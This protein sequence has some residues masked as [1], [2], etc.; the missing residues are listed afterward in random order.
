MTETLRSQPPENDEIDLLQLFATLYEGRH[1]IIAVTLA[2]IVLGFLY[3]LM[4]KP[5]YQADAL[6]QLEEKSGGGLA[7][8]ADIAE[9]FGEAPEVPAEIEILKSRTVLTRTIE[10]LAL[11]ITA[12]P[13]RLPVLGDFLRRWELPDPGFRFLRPYAWHEE[14]IAVSRLIVPRRLQDR[15][16]ILTALGEERYALD[17]GE[18]RV[19]KG[20]VGTLLSDAESGIELLVGRLIGAEGR[21]FILNAAPVVSSLASLRERFSVSE[22]GRKSSILQLVL[23]GPDADEAVRILDE[24]S[25]VYLLQNIA[26]S[27]AEAEASLTFIRDQLP[28]AEARVQAAEEA[29]NRFKEEQSSVDLTFEMRALLEE[30]VQIEAQLNALTLEEFE[31]QKRYTELHPAYKTLI[32]KRTRLD[33]RLTEI[34]RQT[35]ELP[36]T[37]QDILR[38][39]QDLEVA[40]QIYVQLLNRAQELSVLK[41]GTI[42]NVRIIDAAFSNGRPVAPRKRL[43]LTLAALLGLIGGSGLVLLRELLSRGIRSPDEIEALGVPVYATVP[44]SEAAARTGS[45]KHQK[46]LEIEARSDPTSPAVEALRSLRTSLHF[47]LVDTDTN[48]IQITSSKPMEGKSYIAANLATVSAQAGQTVVLVDADLRRGYQHKYFGLPRDTPGLSNILSGTAGIED[49]LVRDPETGLYLITVGRYPP[50]P[51]ELLMHPNFAKLLA[52]L[53]RRFD[54]TIIDTAPLLAVTDPSIIAKYAAMILLVVRYHDV[55]ARELAAAIK[56]LDR[57]GRKATGSVLNG[58]DMKRSS[59]ASSYIYQYDYA[60]RQE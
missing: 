16:L 24:I 2:A 17:I 51:A 18:G 57:V 29:L 36:Q 52:E 15:T 53:D 11:N 3:V 37:Q 26:R 31:L 12:E 55:G 5:V 39:S 45:G 43:V 10:N 58:F 25:Q 46:V 19:L 23:K 54:L 38:R 14:E 34:R 32:E 49:V 28:E 30:A 7:V 33:Q 8:S 35:S 20:R 1:R 27:A 44:T 9:L 6:L 40:R 50:N 56:V 59:Y 47:G 41:A 48:I 22:K 60:S 42:G 4:A 13:R 21:E